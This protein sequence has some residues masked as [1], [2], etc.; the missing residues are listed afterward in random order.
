[1]NKHE[2]DNKIK[3]HFSERKLE[4]SPTAFDRL[5]LETDSEDKTKKFIWLSNS[6]LFMT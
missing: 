3:K 2:L 1:M 6:C 4:V 5:N